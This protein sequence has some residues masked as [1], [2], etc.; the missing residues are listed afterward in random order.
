MGGPGSC[1]R[2]PGDGPGPCP[3]VQGAGQLVVVSPEGYLGG[4]C[5]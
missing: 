5:S 3:T 4:I 2:R 1:W